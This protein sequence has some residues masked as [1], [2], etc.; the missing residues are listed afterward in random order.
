VQDQVAS[1]M[2]GI[3]FHTIDPYPSVNSSPVRL[4]E[5][6]ALELESRLLLVYTGESHLSGDV[7]KK[8]IADYE[9]GVEI[10]LKAM[11]TLRDT[12][13]WAKS[14]MMRGDFVELGE[15][16]N[17]NTAAQKNL[18]PD[19][20]T[21]KIE[22]LEEVARQAGAMGFKINGAGGGGSVTLL[23]ASDNTR[24]VEAAVKRAGYRVL[25][26]HLDDR[27]LRAWVVTSDG[28]G[29]AP[30]RRSRQRSP[31]VEAERRGA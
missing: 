26:C 31:Y 6:V 28:R 27:G 2:G 18:H 22:V 19:I 3:G 11:D 15:I 16:M 13:M 8:V 5:S 23:C 12:P 7:H 10:T 25:P 17:V 9:A 14:A 30:M 21:D 4:S 1:A 24:E 29:N 20:T